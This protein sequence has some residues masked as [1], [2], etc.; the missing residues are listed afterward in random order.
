M[1]KSKINKS[2]I[3]KE[4]IKKLFGN[5]VVIFATHLATMN[6]ALQSKLSYTDSV[7]ICIGDGF[8]LHLG[9]TALNQRFLTYYL[10]QQPRKQDFNGKSDKTFVIPIVDIVIMNPPFTRHERIAG[11][12]LDTIQNVLRQEG[13][14]NY[15]A[16]KMS[17]QHYFLLHA[18]S[19]LKKNGKL[20]FV[21][22]TNTFNVELSTKI[23][24]FLEE[25]KYHIEYL[26]SNNSKKGAFSEDSNF[27]EYLFI[28][29]KGILLKK[30]LTKLVMLSDLPKYEGVSIIT[31]K[32]RKSEK[33]ESFKQD[34]ISIEIKI[35]N[36]N[37]LYK[38]NKWDAEFWEISDEN[39]P[40][41]FQNDKLIKLK[42]SKEF[43]FITGFH[44]THCE[45]LMIPNRLFSIKKDLGDHGIQLTRIEDNE[46]VILSRDILRPALREP[47]LYKKI[48]AEPT[49]YVLSLGRTDKLD[50]E[51][52]QKYLEYSTN[53]LSEIIRTKAEA[54]GKVKDELDNFWY[55]HPKDTGC[56]QKTGHLWTFNRYGIWK[57]NN[58]SIYTENLITANDG[59]HIY[60]YSGKKNESKALK[61]L[62]SWFNTSIH[63]YDFLGKC[64]VPAK[65]VQQVLKPERE[66]MY[67]PIISQLSED[68]MDEILI[69]SREFNDNVNEL[70][71]NQFKAK[72]RRK[73]DFVWLKILGMP[74][75]KIPTFLNELYKKLETIIQNR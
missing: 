73:L 60:N 10:N 7:N 30:S 28:A 46:T 48:Y 74:E 5:D 6:L 51:F 57:R 50:V 24:D 40:I 2:Q 67:V 18:D 43:S 26:I 68:N 16:G 38:S 39:I 64:R 9:E 45:Y 72:F 70:I 44:S 54:G 47:K 11:E 65:H 15:I 21:V 1:P 25:K 75:N 61:V 14:G 33:N 31:E 3:H 69:V 63:L 29:S 59:F 17:L 56:D 49:H 32:I 8:Q 66:E 71:I 34:D 62:N 42:E 55:C 41:L 22:P 52:S 13:Y 37:D 53:K 36:T 27:K 20:A 19:F 58:L 23:I 12:F 4:L 35:I